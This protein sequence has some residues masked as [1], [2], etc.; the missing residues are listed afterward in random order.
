MHELKMIPGSARYV[1]RNPTGLLVS[2][3]G[4]AHPCQDGP[5]L[6]TPAEVRFSMACRFVHGQGKRGNV[7]TPAIMSVASPDAVVLDVFI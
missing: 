7:H 1:I 6:H 3:Y 4:K 2:C 5:V